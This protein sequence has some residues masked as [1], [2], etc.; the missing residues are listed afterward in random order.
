MRAHQIYT[1][2]NKLEEVKKIQ[3]I[4]EDI[5]KQYKLDP[6]IAFH[7]DVALDE[8]ITNVISYGYPN[9]G[10]HEIHIEIHSIQS[11]EDSSEKLE[12]KIIDQGIAF[13]PTKRLKPDIELSVE[14]R[15]IGGLGIYFVKT[16][17]EG[18]HYERRGDKNILTLILKLNKNLT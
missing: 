7:L 5:A 3:H 12:I 6:T 14:D 17:M 2:F 8:L 15:A 16:F 18:M 1:L 11:V 4:V 9:G 13:D 10:N